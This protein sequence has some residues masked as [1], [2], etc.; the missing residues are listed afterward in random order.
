MLNVFD[1]VNA[2]YIHLYIT[3]CLARL[4]KHPLSLTALLLQDCTCICTSSIA[5]ATSY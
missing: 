3:R 4:I 1:I 5:P 2:Y